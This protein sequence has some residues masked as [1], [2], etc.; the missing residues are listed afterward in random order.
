VL[1]HVGIYPVQNSRIIGLGYL[2]EKII[3]RVCHAI[4]VAMWQPPVNG[5]RAQSS[6]RAR[7]PQTNPIPTAH[8]AGTPILGRKRLRPTKV[9]PSVI[10]SCQCAELRFCDGLSL[11][12]STQAKLH[13]KRSM[14]AE[15]HITVA[16]T[17]ISLLAG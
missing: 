9:T 11:G 6:C 14:V 10:S 4:N 17:V 12:G 5:I 15:Y 2:D 1:V 16:A 3:K 7:Y 13:G 8:G